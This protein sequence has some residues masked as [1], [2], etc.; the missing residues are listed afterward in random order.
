TL[1]YLRFVW[2]AAAAVT[3]TAYCLWA[4]DVAQTPSSF[5]WA[6]WSVLPFVLAILRYA[7][8]VDRGAAEAPETAALGDRVLVL[9]GGAWLILFGL[10]AVGV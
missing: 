8:T 5:P 10:G 1:G 4:F 6:A 9:L 2:G 7:I 3:I